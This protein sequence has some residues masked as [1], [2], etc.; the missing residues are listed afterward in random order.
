MN[1]RP[2]LVCETAPPSGRPGRRFAT[3]L[4]LRVEDLPARFEV[5]SLFEHGRAP[6]EGRKAAKALDVEGRD[7]VLLGSRVAA[8]FGLRDAAPLSTVE[9]RGARLHVLPNLSS[10]WWREH[11]TWERA[12]EYLH[13]VL[14]TAVLHADRVRPD[15]AWT[16]D[17]DVTSS[18]DEMLDRSIPDLRNMRRA[19]SDV[20]ARF[21]RPSTWVVDLGSSRGSQ[22]ADF[23]A[24]LPPGVRVCASEVSAPMLDV[25]RTRFAPEVADGRVDVLDLDLRRSYPHRAASAT[26]SV[27]ALQFVP[28]EHRQRI[29][30]DAF[31][32]T[33]PGGVFVL[34]E[35]VL[36]ADAEIDAAMVDLYHRFKRGNGYAREDVERKRLSLE[37]VLVPV[38]ARW[39]EELLRSAGFVSVDCFWRWMNFAAWIAIRPA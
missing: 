8:A 31:R 12:S 39:N 38:T 21:A 34:V 22:V 9:A 10:R 1:S 35:K 25:L 24:V 28:I 2:L 16:F 26:T 36:G 13:A 23:L 6:A 27:L 17:G 4:G 11:G 37:G 20:V 30:R 7:V 19:V 29:L 14:G 33:V 18:F 32:N 15:G 3:L 5:R